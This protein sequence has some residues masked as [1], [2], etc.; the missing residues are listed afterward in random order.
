MTGATLSLG[1]YGSASGDLAISFA[2]GDLAVTATDLTLTVGPSAGIH[3]TMSHATLGLLVRSVSGAAKVAVLFSGDIAIANGTSPLLTASGWRFAL[4]QLAGLAATPVTLSTGL[5]SVLVDLADGTIGFSGSGVLP[6]G[7]FGTVSGSYS[8]VLT[9]STPSLAVTV[10]GGVVTLTFPG[11]SLALT[12][13]AGRVTVAS[14]GVTFESAGPLTGTG[15]LAVGSIGSLSGVFTVTGDGATRT[16]GATGV[17][18]RLAAGTVALTLTNGTG[19]LTSDS[20]HTSG[21]VSGDVSLDGVPGVAVSGSFK[22]SADSAGT[23][24][25]SGD[26]SVTLA[27]VALAGKVTITKSTGALMV[28]V[29]G[30]SVSG[31]LTL[32]SDGST[33]APAP[34]RWPSRSTCRARACRARPASRSARPPRPSR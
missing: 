25:V 5:G 27:G 30:A 12:G 26:G 33:P 7:T 13:L 18:A 2:G 23:F 4:N 17:T 3:A 11:A 9:T 21:L 28:A 24:S 20:T 34:S 8:I 1:D 10:T 32:N 31:S 6:L 15:T 19:S 16:I 29:T 22:L 14:S